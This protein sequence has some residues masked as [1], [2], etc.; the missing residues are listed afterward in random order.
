MSLCHCICRCTLRPRPGRPPARLPCWRLSWR[1][2][3]RR[4][5]Q[6]RSARQQCRAHS[7]CRRW[8]RPGMASSRPPGGACSTPG[9]SGRSSS[10]LAR[11][12]AVP[13]C[14]RGAAAAAGRR[15]LAPQASESEQLKRSE[16]KVSLLQTLAALSRLGTIEP[17]FKCPGFRARHEKLCVLR[18][19]EQRHRRCRG[20]ACWTPGPRGQSRSNRNR[21]GQQAKTPER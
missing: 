2:A 12:S 3:P 17:R 7:G 15:L 5:C 20:G 6:A 4:R 13:S 18:V 14:S 16:P 1:P 19:R 10:S 11:S 9:L 8:W 21:S